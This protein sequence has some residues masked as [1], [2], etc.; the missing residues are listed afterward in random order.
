MAD[1]IRPNIDSREGFSPIGWERIEGG[2]EAAYQ[3]YLEDG[4]DVT[5]E[6]YDEMCDYWES[7]EGDYDD[8]DDGQP[9]T[10]TEWQDLYEGDDWDFGQYDEY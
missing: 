3:A 2:D 7:L 9:D 10:W 1:E 8:I 6:D 5:N 4:G